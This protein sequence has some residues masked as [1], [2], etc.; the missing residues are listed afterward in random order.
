[1]K[2]TYLFI[3]ACLFASCNSPKSELDKT[4]PQ[5]VKT[6]EDSPINCYM[7]ASESDTIILNLNST[8]NSISGTLVYS[9][10]EKDKNKGTIQGSIKG[11][12]LVADYTFMSEGVTSTRQVAFKMEGN[13]YVEGYGDVYT[14]NEKVQF[15]NL[16][17]LNFNTSMK[18]AEVSCQ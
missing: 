7:Y 3:L 9:F 12:M 10:K 6:N 4:S 18:L 13:H 5:V 11:N 16:G 14:Q 17:S 8:G 15:K 1:M 2:T